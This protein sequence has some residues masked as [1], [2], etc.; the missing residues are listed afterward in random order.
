M[1]LTFLSLTFSFRKKNLFL[2]V[3]IAGSGIT[4]DELV[5]LGE[6]Y[7]KSEAFLFLFAWA[8]LKRKKHSTIFSG[9]QCANDVLTSF[10]HNSNIQ[11]S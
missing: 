4:R 9:F 8:S 11:V 3:P 7:G 5:L 10:C 2:V 6:K 1:F